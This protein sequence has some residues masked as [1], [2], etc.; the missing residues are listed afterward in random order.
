MAENTYYISLNQDF[1]SGS[2]INRAGYKVRKNIL[3][4][5]KERCQYNQN[6]FFGWR[7]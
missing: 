4:L 3:L 5:G 7:S 6:V 2:Y 1:L